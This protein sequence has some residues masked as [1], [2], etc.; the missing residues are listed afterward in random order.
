[1]YTILIAQGI[2]LIHFVKFITLRA[3]KRIVYILLASCLFP[4]SSFQTKLDVAALD[5]ALQNASRTG[6]VLFLEEIS[7]LT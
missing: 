3:M 4:Q 5:I 6:Q 7:G 1:M 2:L